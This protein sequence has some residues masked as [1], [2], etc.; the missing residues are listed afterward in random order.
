MK[1]PSPLPDAFW[2]AIWIEA[3]QR[4]W[5]AGMCSEIGLIIM[6]VFFGD[7]FER[8]YNRDFD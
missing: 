6:S 5:R 3:G 8:L 2:A 7:N 4:A 1:A